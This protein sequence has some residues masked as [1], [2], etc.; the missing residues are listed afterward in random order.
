[1]SRRGAVPSISL[2]SQSFEVPTMTLNKQTVQHITSST[3]TQ[4]ASGVLWQSGVDRGEFLL[5]LG[6]PCIAGH[7][8]FMI[9][10]QLKFLQLLEDLLFLKRH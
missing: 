1:M 4:R 9:T 8:V 5:K 6:D 10:A 3:Q 2:W 7:D